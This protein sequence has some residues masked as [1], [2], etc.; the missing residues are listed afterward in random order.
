[1]PASIQF[2][3]A[4]PSRAQGATLR[5]GALGNDARKRGVDSTNSSAVKDFI[6]PIHVN[7]SDCGRIVIR[8][9]TVPSP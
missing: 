7:I 2:R 3:P 6:A 5:V 8:K 9:V 1:V 4:T